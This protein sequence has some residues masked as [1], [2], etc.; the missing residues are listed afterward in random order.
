MIA[1]VLVGKTYRSSYILKRR[2]SKDSLFRFPAVRAGDRRRFNL[3]GHQIPIIARTRVGDRRYH[4][5]AWLSVRCHAPLVVIKFKH[6]LVQDLL[7]G[8]R[9]FSK[10]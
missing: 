4:S 7:F 6:A 8:K 10:V 3:D 2:F 9:D 5:R 1:A